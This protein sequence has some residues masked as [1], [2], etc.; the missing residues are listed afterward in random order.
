MLLAT[1]DSASGPGDPAEV[2][3]PTLLQVAAKSANGEAAAATGSAYK[4]NEVGNVIGCFVPI[5]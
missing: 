4:S 2:T 1:R 5:G 3:E